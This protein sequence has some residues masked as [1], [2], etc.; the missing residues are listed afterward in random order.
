MSTARVLDDQVVPVLGADEAIAVAAEIGADLARTSA[1]RDSDRILPRAGVGPPVRLRAARGHR[2]RR[3]RR[4]DV[5]QATLAEVFRLLASAD[6][7]LAQIP[8]SHFVYVNVMRRQGTPEQG[9]SSSARCSRGGG[10]ATPSPRRAPSTY[11]TSA[12]RLDPDAGRRL[13]G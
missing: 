13:S 3:V 5:R 8:Q 6:P 7:S 9:S 2:A 1:R 12:P 4:S 10:S 11:R